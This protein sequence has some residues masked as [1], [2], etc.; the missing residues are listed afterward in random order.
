VEMVAALSGDRVGRLH[1]D[2][3]LPPLVA[4]V[5]TQLER[6]AL[7]GTEP[8]RIDLTVAAERERSRTLHRLRVL[9]VPGFV[10]DTGP[11]TGTD[12]ILTEHWSPEPDDDRLVALIE[13]GAYGPT[14]AAAALGRLGERVEDAGSDVDALAA[15]LFDAALCGCNDLSDQVLATIS[16]SIA[17]VPELGRL[18][19]VLAV[20]L[21]LWRHDQLLGTARSTTLGAVLTASMDRLLW[22]AEGI[23]GTTLPADP[24][25]LAALAAARDTLVHAGPALRIDGS[26]A[27]TVMRRIAADPQAPPD[28][29]GAAAGFGWSLGTEVDPVRA[30]R[31]AATPKRLGDWLA[32][33][34]ALAREEVLAADRHDGVLAAV[35]SL[36]GPMS[37]HEFLIALPALRQAFAFFPPRERET[38]A[39]HLLARRGLSGSGRSLVRPEAEPMA[40]A[41]A[42]ALDA[43]VDALLVREG[44]IT[45]GEP[46]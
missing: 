25:R 1:P 17:V 10:R 4:D 43:Y 26:V 3:P 39:R 41:R 29:R 23:H 24:A 34:F 38:I 11:V 27:L 6:H 40:I 7:T 44:L 20:V 8:V 45:I 33:L 12:P 30:V 46:S 16:R 31:G 32:G 42:H 9:G 14:L 15:V 13:A 19:R 21:R 18:G 2:T 36:L 28:L 22:L 35:D 5:A 37:E